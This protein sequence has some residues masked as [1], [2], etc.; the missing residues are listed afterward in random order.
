MHWEVTTFLARKA[1]NLTDASYCKF[2][3][4]VSVVIE[5]GLKSNTSFIISV[6]SPVYTPNIPVTRICNDT[7]LSRFNI[8]HKMNDCHCEIK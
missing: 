3:L 7:E 4:T 5:G 2:L 1:R 6:A 8:H